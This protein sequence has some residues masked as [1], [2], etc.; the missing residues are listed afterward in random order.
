MKVSAVLDGRIEDV[1]KKRIFNQFLFIINIY[2]MTEYP[3]KR[4][5]TQKNRKKYPKDAPDN[6]EHLK[7]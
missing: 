4:G 2:N 1:T 3:I 5:M 6:A 7:K